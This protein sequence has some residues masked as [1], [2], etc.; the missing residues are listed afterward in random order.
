MFA[1]HTADPTF[2]KQYS[3]IRSGGI[4]RWMSRDGHERRKGKAG[5]GRDELTTQLRNDK[6]HRNICRLLQH[7]FHPNTY[8]GREEKAS[9]Q[10]K[11]RERNKKERK[12]KGERERKRRKN[13]HVRKRYKRQEESITGN[14]KCLL[15]GTKLCFCCGLIGPSRAQAWLDSTL[16]LHSHSWNSFRHGKHR[17]KLSR[18]R[19]K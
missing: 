2:V 11:E 4:Q 17:M 15:F 1:H 16:F 19:I 13:E 8:G 14:K 5:D 9:R 10:R 7:I 12:R 18:T 6:Y 3:V